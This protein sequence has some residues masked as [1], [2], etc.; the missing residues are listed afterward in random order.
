MGGGGIPWG[1][2]G[3]GPDTGHGTIYIYIYISIENS[4]LQNSDLIL[5]IYI[6][7]SLSPRA[8]FKVD[9]G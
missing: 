8:F 5:R 7:S 6:I 4:V 3:G 2:V 1:G 9:V